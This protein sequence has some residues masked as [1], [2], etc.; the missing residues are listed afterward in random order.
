MNGEI[1]DIVLT[2][3]LAAVEVGSWVAVYWPDDD[4]YHVATVTR[5]RNKKKPLYLEYDDGSSEWVDLRQHRFHLIPGGTRRR[6]EED[7][8][9]EDVESDVDLGSQV[10]N[11]PDL[12]GDEN[13]TNDSELK[14]AAS[15]A[16]DNNREISDGSQ[17]VTESVEL[18]AKAAVALR[19]NSP[20]YPVGTKVKKVG[21][22][23]RNS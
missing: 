15:L 3:D 20:K 14:M 8:I 9:L 1:E 11:D 21:V 16:E 17:G 10:P 4:R 5:E 13:D 22:A 12:D 23:Q 19:E 6:W 18:V 2:S 7:D